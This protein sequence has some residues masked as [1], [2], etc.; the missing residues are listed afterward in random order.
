MKLALH[1]HGLPNKT[2]VAISCH[3]QGSNLRTCCIKIQTD[4]YGKCRFRGK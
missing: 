4:V 3:G 1:P 2:N